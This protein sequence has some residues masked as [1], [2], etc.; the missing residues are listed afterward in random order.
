L[1]ARG[2]LALGLAL[3]CLLGPSTDLPGLTRL[4]GAYLAVDGALATLSAFGCGVCWGT[5]LL[6]GAAGFFLGS[7]LLLCADQLYPLLGHAIVLWS[8]T[9]AALHLV[10]A[11][12]VGQGSRSQWLFRAAG[13]VLILLGV[14]FL[15]SPVSG[16][17]VWRPWLCIFLTLYGALLTALGIQY[18][19]LRP[20]R[21]EQ[22]LG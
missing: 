6:A 2:L 15:S 3:V 4:F 16:V 20:P 9:L 14:V 12:E 11:S 5:L 10:S 21:G 22:V 13:I 19:T 18:R 7:L 17:A 8:L 1:I